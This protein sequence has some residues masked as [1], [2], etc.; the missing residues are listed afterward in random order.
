MWRTVAYYWEKGGV[1]NG[2][3]FVVCCVVV[4]IGLG[5]LRQYARYRRA[6]TR[7][8]GLLGQPGCSAAAIGE[9]GDWLARRLLDEAG[10]MPRSASFYRNRLREILLE[11]VPRLESGLDTMAAW[12]A[13]APLLGLLGTVFGMIRTFSIIMEFGVGN[14]NLLS[15]GISVSLLTT[16][17]G[18]LVAFPCLLFH[19]VLQDRKGALVKALIADGERLIGCLCGESSHA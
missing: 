18:L 13:A 15:E 11:Q 3:I 1:I 8:V 7:L 17:A 5:K 6:R 10:G 4:Y 14:P 9:S 12:I 19:N 16:Q 2:L